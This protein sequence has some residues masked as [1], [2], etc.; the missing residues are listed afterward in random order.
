MKK[1]VDFG[2]KQPRLPGLHWV[3]LHWSRA[4]SLGLSKPIFSVSLSGGCVRTERGVSEA[5]RLTA[6]RNDFDSKGEEYRGEGNRQP[7]VLRPQCVGWGQVVPAS[8][9]VF[10][11]HCAPHVAPT[12]MHVV[13][14]PSHQQDLPSYVP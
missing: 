13:V 12:V 2:L 8:R 1:T 7:R 5:G 6:T 14:I 10:R 3:P 11:L 9:R 4:P